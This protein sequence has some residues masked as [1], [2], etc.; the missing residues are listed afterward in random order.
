MADLYSKSKLREAASTFS[1]MVDVKKAREILGPDYD[2]M[3]DE[4]IQHIID[5]L[6]AVCSL[7]IEEYLKEKNSK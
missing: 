2:T 3:T 1:K 6:S 5:Y 4:E 7:V